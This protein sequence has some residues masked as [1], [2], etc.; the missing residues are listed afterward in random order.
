MRRPIQ[1]AGVGHH[2]EIEDRVQPVGGADLDLRT[3]QADANGMGFTREVFKAV[4]AAVE[5]WDRVSETVLVP[6]V[7]P[8]LVAAVKRSPPRLIARSSDSHELSGS[9]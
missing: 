6:N 5:G 4:G 1:V 2:A 9:K 3:G 7:D 8:G